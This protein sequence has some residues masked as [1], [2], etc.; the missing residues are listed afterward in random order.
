MNKSTIKSRIT[1]LLVT[2]S[3]LTIF[4]LI[5][6]YTDWLN[7]PIRCYE[8][9][10]KN[11]TLK[12][13]IKSK[14]FCIEHVYLPYQKKQGS[15]KLGIRTKLKDKSYLYTT[16]TFWIANELGEEKFSDIE[17]DFTTDRQTFGGRQ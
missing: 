16:T 14:D 11:N 6:N 1:V 7:R 17:G 4:G 13:N 9:D 3:V 12:E 15:V 2:S 10:G 8:I 5:E